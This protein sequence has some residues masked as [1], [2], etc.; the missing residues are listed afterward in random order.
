MCSHALK[1]LALPHARSM[2]CSRRPRCTLGAA[3]VLIAHAVD[4]DVYTF[5]RLHLCTCWHGRV[6]RSAKIGFVCTMKTSGCSL[7]VML[8][9]TSWA[10]CVESAAFQSKSLVC[11]ARGTCAVLRLLTVIMM[12]GSWL[13]AHDVPV[14]CQSHLLRV[15]KA[16][17]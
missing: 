11:C 7:S 2:A 10:C 6:M 17:F 14:L 15:R 4:T 5:P 16:D 3:R 9:G 12:L 13:R 1:E 8:L